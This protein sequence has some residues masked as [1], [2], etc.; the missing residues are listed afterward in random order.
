MRTTQHGIV[1]LA[2]HGPV[3]DG[4]TPLTTLAEF[5]TLVHNIKLAASAS[6]GIP[7]GDTLALREIVD[8]IKHFEETH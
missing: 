1:D 5:I 3:T 7:D 4:P 8:L 6:R 2:I